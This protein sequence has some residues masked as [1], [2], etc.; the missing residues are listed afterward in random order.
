[1]A[2]RMSSS[3][4][5]PYCQCELTLQ[6]GGTKRLAR[7]AIW[8]CLGA[9]VV[10]A[11]ARAFLPTFEPPAPDPAW[12]AETRRAN[13]DDPAKADDLIAKERVRVEGRWV[14]GLSDEQ[15]SVLNLRT[16]LGAAII[17]LLCV[18]VPAAILFVIIR[19]EPIQKRPPPG[20]Q[21]RE[22]RD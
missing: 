15:K 19:P 6:D 2:Q 4:Q 10:A 21:G 18:G 7:A 16:A 1:M 20:N 13:K 12:V 17:V 9:L 11:A 5:C 22:T 14:Q 3:L 8:F